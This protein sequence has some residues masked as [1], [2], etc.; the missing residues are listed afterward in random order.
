MSKHILP[1]NATKLERALAAAASMQHTPEVIKTLADSQRCPVE[2]LPWLAWA[3]SVDEWQDDWPEARKRAAVR[4]AVEL[5]RKKGTPWAV[6]RAL[7]VHGFDDCEIIEY[8]TFLQDW[9][10][11]GGKYLDGSWQ[12]NGQALSPNVPGARDVVRSAALNHWAQY[13]IRVNSADVSWNRAQQ[14]RLAAVAR[15]YAP[16]LGCSSHGW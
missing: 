16:A 15:R 13:A 14:Q 11:S 2:F 1:P 8:T 12:L 5:H 4:S 3:M 7:A 6:L 9:Q 10:A